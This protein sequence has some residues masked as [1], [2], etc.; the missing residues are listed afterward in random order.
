[1]GRRGQTIEQNRTEQVILGFLAF[2][3]T[4][5]RKGGM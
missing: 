3:L 1:M 4:E 5:S 2:M